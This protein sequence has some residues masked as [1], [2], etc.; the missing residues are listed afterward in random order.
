VKED[1]MSANTGEISTSVEL[2]RRPRR[3]LARTEAVPA[4]AIRRR[5]ANVGGA[6]RWASVVA[7]PLA[8]RWA[9]RSRR[10]SVPTRLALFAVGT[11]L[12]ERGVTGVCRLYRWLGVDSLRGVPHTGRRVLE[13]AHSDL[14]AAS[15]RSV[16]RTVTIMRPLAE[17]HATLRNVLRWP[18][19]VD[20]I[21]SVEARDAGGAVLHLRGADGRRLTCVLALVQD[22]PDAE[23]VWDVSDQG[24]R[25]LGRLIV[26]LGPAAGAR[27]TE[28]RLTAQVEGDG[29]GATMTVASWAA[30]LAGEAPEQQVRRI[31]RRFKQLMETGEITTA[32][33]PSGTRQSDPVLGRILRT[34]T[35]APPRL[36]RSPGSSQTTAREED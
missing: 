24:G 17:L 33:G 26:A 22:Q 29:D 10:T 28:V 32:A 36:P 14:V 19:F 12:V 16:E 4:H 2:T 3:L 11:L 7:G 18:M 5:I 21:E 6:E 23:L 34:R 15:R 13:E 1:V 8:L 9:A 31:L 25:R 20:A 30:K 35:D 27:G